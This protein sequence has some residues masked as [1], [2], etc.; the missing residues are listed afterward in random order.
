[1]SETKKRGGRKSK[2]Y[3]HIQPYLEHIAQMR[4]NGCTLDQIGE[5]FKVSHESINQYKNLHPEFADILKL[6]AEIA[7][8]AV[9]NALFKN[10]VEHN[11]LAAQI[12]FLKN[13]ASNKWKDKQHVFQTGTT[14]IKRDY[15]HLSDDELEQEYEKLDTI[16]PEEIEQEGGEVH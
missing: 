12:F 15:E 8:L 9:E 11:N 16:V 14:T 2:Y 5:M 10:A 6:N 1:M 13:R 3:T 4:R 7:V